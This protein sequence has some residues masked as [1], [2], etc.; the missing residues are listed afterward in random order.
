MGKKLL[1][2][3]AGLLA[4]TVPIA[5]GIINAPYIR[6]Q[7]PQSAVPKFEVAAIKP[8]EDGDGGQRAQFPSKFS[9]GRMSLNCQTLVG[10]ILTAY[11]RFADGRTSRPPASLPPIEG[12]PAWLKSLR[13][14]IDAKAEGNASPELM[15]GP[16]LQALLEDRFKLK[17]HRGTREIP[18]YELTVSKSGL[19]LPKFKEGSCASRP[20]RDLT[21][22]FGPP[23]ALPTGQKYC[24]ALGTPKGPNMVVDAQG[25]SLEEFAKSFLSPFLNASDARPVVDKTGVTGKFDFH[26][27]FALDEAMRRALDDD[28]GEPT[29]PSIFTAL[30]EQL[31]L[32]LEGAKGPGETIVIDSVEK[33]SEN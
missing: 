1:L 10:H 32:K 3:T 30:Q 19:K 24:A 28:P 12:G 18:V 27:E 11:V 21:K 20:P 7:S 14:T 31:G 13:Y 8:C 33:P 22:A 26:L 5:V 16:M 4:V 15:Q 2:A 6:A 29:A 25:F 23:P 9:P 17:I